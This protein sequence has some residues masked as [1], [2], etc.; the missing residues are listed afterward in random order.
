MELLEAA[1]GADYAHCARAVGDDLAA[2]AELAVL[3]DRY[4]TDTHWQ[5][6]Q[7]LGEAVADLALDRGDL[8]AQVG[9]LQDQIRCLEG[10]LRAL[11]GGDQR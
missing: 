2:V 1:L 3:I 10:L 11:A 8:A 5:A 9:R 7:R 6:L 4:G